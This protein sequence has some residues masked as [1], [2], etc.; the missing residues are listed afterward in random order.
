MA[1]TLFKSYITT[2]PDP[3]ILIFLCCSSVCACGHHY[4]C[5]RLGITVYHHGPQ[6][7]L[8]WSAELNR[9]NGF[10]LPVQFRIEI[11]NGLIE[12]QVQLCPVPRQA[13]SHSKLSESGTSYLSGLHISSS[14]RFVSTTTAYRWRS[15]PRDSPPTQVQ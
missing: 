15:Q 13:G 9:E 1:P 10:S 5:L 4:D 2:Q 7:Y 6:S 8:Q 14:D 11:V 12:G 3:G